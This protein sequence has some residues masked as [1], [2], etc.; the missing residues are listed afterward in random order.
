MQV[1]PH[2]L[3]RDVYPGFLAQVQGEQLGGPVRRFLSYLVGISFND[4]Q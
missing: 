3:L 1:N 4:A 2:G